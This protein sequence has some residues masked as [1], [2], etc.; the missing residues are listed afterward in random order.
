MKK[1]LIILIII[2]ELIMLIGGAMLLLPSII[3]PLAL[4]LIFLG[5]IGTIVFI[6]VFWY[7]FW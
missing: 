4:A 5:G 3:V 7:E 6:L 2:S 1:L